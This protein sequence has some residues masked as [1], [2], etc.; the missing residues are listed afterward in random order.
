M[1]DE[2]PRTTHAQQEQQRPGGR[3]AVQPPLVIDAC[4]LDLTF[5][6]NVVLRDIS[7]RVREGEALAIVGPSGVG[8]S[9]I[10]KIILRLLVPNAGQMLI[11][12]EDINQLSFEEVLQVRQKMGMVFQAPALFDS[13]SV[14]ENVA[15]PLREHRRLTEQQ[16][17]QQ[18]GNS[19]S[20]VD[21]SL[22]EFGNR[23]PAE[24][25]GG[26]KK[27]VGI[28]RAIIH[29]PK[30]LLYDEPT[31]GLDPLTGR[32]IVKLI[33]RLQAE[34]EVTSVVVSHDVRAVLEIATHIAMLRD[35]RIIFYGSPE[36]F[37]RASDPYIR[38]FI[39]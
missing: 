7:F 12:G 3:T 10:L 27:R 38:E 31:T 22:E 35:S 4:N 20:L 15:F 32:T 34:L 16:I 19:L 1:M 23:L 13:L 36:E 5:G 17:V 33:K 14:F 39:D 21:M 9:T 11:D 29:E 18:V 28:A 6:D 30:I 24:L 8:K 25:S 2:H 26:Q 37:V